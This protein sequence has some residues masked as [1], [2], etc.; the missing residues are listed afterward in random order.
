[1]DPEAATWLW[2]PPWLG[3]PRNARLGSEARDA[4]E[5]AARRRTSVLSRTLNGSARVPAT[6]PSSSTVIFEKSEP[7]QVLRRL[8]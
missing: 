6:V 7:S 5:E 1:V 2:A 3:E 8:F 4:V